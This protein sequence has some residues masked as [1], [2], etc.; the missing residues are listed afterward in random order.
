M[1][2]LPNGGLGKQRVK[3]K[4][5]QNIEYCREETNHPFKQQHFANY[6]KTGNFD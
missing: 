2:A 1:R 6:Y 5:K 3:L 4:W